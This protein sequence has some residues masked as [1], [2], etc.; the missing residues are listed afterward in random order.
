M[1][2]YHEVLRK[3][4]EFLNISQIELAEIA[5]IS[6]RSLQE[7]EAGKSN[8]GINQLKKILDVLG[9]E[10]KIEIKGNI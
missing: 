3:R 2:N 10:I 1:D 8:P 6:R 4:R 9:F 7:I 5:G